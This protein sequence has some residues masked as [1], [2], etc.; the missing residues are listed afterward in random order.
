MK[1]EDAVSP[2]VGVM[3]M[4]V[5]TIIIAAVVSGFAGGLISGQEKSPTL[6]MDVT[7][8]NT[9]SYIGSGFTASVLGV[10]EPISTTDLKIVTSWSTTMK[11]NTDPG[12]T[13][14]QKTISNGNTFTGGNTSLPNSANV[15]CYQGMK[16]KT[17]TNW[18]TA[19]FGIG[20]GVDQTNPTDPMGKSADAYQKPGWFGQFTLQEGVNLFAY[21]YGSDSGQAI[22]G[23]LS[24][25]ADSGYNGETLYAYKYASG[26]YEEG[27]A[28]P[29]QA[30]L[31][32][33]WEQLRAGDTVN[34]KVIYTPTGAAIY[35]SNIAVED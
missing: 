11:D 30:L 25:P 20:A 5:V 7:I 16:T 3:L 29:T 9:G 12:L 15:I 14:Q 1:N 22:A 31:G 17:V 10:S 21:P 24:E 32:Y 13:E 8:A 28:D 35:N 19:P 27:Q 26:L 23:A 4:L 6:S 33:G 18:S 2:V 34:V